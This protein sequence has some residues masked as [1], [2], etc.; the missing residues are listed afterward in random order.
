VRK[1]TY[2]DDVP[3]SPGVG[4]KE[5]FVDLLE[6]TM[7]GLGKEEVDGGNHEEVDAREDGVRV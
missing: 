1:R 5:D 2:L 6:G 3:G 7:S 4:V